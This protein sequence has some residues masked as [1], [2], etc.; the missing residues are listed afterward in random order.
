VSGAA[1]PLDPHHALAALAALLS[2]RRPDAIASLAQADTG[3]FDPG[4]FDA[5]F[6]A[7]GRRFGRELVGGDATIADAAGRPWSIASWALDEA[8]RALLLLRAANIL[9]EPE[10]LVWIERLYRTGALR[11][12]QAILKVLAALPGPER[13]L[14]VALDAGRASTQPLFEAI[15]CENPYPARHFPEP[16]FNQMTLKAVFTDVPLRRILGLDGRRTHELARM[17]ADYASERRAAGR[18]V[19]ADLGLLL[20]EGGDIR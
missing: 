4:A 6:A 11:E 7:A 12:R 17:A 13:F 19:P 9:P 5:A 15:A 2:E 10:H 20:E 1:E 3:P 16:A 8:G 14:P 18:S